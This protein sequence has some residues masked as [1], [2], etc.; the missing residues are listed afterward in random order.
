MAVGTLAVF[1]WQ[2]NT[3]ADLETARTAAMTTMVMCQAFH[4]G[5][6]R[7]ETI[8]A[9]RLGPLRNPS[10]CSRRPRP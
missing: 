9:F 1:R 7:S 3:R 2:L 8:S 6:A 4:V 5:N 10:S